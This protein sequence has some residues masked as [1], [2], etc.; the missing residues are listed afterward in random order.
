MI[1]RGFATHFINNRWDNSS[2][3]FRYRG[4]QSLEHTSVNRLAAAAPPRGSDQ[5]SRKHDTWITWFVENNTTR[6]FAFSKSLLLIIS[7]R[8]SFH[9]HSYQTHHIALHHSPLLITS[10]QLIAQPTAICKAHPTITSHSSC[11]VTT[12]DPLR[13]DSQF[14][15]KGCLL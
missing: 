12:D 11:C 15:R 3:W 10:L 2:G 1:R 9:L 6:L 13:R 8:L 5:T 7:N 14:G 4:K